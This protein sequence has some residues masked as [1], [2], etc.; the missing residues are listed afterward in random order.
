MAWIGFQFP[1]S[2]QI[3][4]D[5]MFNLRMMYKF[6]IDANGAK[7]NIL[8]CVQILNV[9]ARTK[10]VTTFNVLVLVMSVIFGLLGAFAGAVICEYIYYN[11]LDQALRTGFWAFIG[12]LGAM[13]VK[14]ALGLVV[15]GIFIWRSWNWHKASSYDRTDH[16]VTQ[17][18]PIQD[19]LPCGNAVTY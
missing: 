4:W 9:R 10:L 11:S 16:F 18:S 14:F 19:S 17:H 1:A 7:G 6:W 5:V 8:S 12:K 15:L 2:V 3:A 13:F